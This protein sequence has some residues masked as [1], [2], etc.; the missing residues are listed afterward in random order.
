MSM[1]L[2][3]KFDDGE[4]L[5]LEVATVQGWGDF[6]RWAGKLPD[7]FQRV[8]RLALKGQAEGTAELEAELKAA[9]KEH[10]PEASAGAVLGRVIEVVPHEGTIAVSEEPDDSEF[11]DED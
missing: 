3:C 9:A 6:C 11:D 1:Y 2:N 7:K 5:A 8:R 4:R 10:P